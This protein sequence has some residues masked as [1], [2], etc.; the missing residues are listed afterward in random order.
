M[1]V[2][3]RTESNGWRVEV[4]KDDAT[5][6]PLIPDLPGV[7]EVVLAGSVAEVIEKQWD[8][9]LDLVKYMEYLKSKGSLQPKEMTDLYKCHTVVREGDRFYPRLVFLHEI[10]HISRLINLPRGWEICVGVN[11][12]TPMKERH[13]HILAM[14]RVMRE[15]G[16]A[17]LDNIN[18]NQSPRLLRPFYGIPRRIDRDANEDDKQYILDVY[19]GL[20]RNLLIRTWGLKDSHPCLDWTQM[21]WDDLLPLLDGHQVTRQPDII[22]TWH[23]LAGHGDY[24]KGNLPFHALVANKYDPNGRFQFH[25]P[26]TNAPELYR[27]LLSA[28]PEEVHPEYFGLL[29]LLK[30]GTSYQGKSGSIPLSYLVRHIHMACVSSWVPFFNDSETMEKL[31]GIGSRGMKRISACLHHYLEDNDSARAKLFVDLIDKYL[32]DHPELSEEFVSLPSAS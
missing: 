16:L 25:K 11:E 7:T 32:S 18:Y 3:I 1:S 8:N 26:F 10:N 27:R 15:L 22:N 20:G 12:E 5:L 6:S 21:L 17:D 13:H 29:H 28:Y 24:D 31:S 23:L 14:G 30:S 19:W 2:L 4:D 9:Y